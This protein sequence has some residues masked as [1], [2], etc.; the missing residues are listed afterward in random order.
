MLSILCVIPS[1]NQNKCYWIV[2][3][4]VESSARCFTDMYAKD[5]KNEKKNKQKKRTG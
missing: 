3:C 5:I 1:F 2:A 4:D